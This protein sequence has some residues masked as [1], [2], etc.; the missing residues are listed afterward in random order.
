MNLQLLSISSSERRDVKKF[1]KKLLAFALLVFVLDKGLAYWA[2][3]AVLHDTRA[4]GTLSLLY[5]GEVNTQIVFF[6]SSKTHVNI[7][8]EAVE[9]QT[10]MSAYNLALGNSSIEM[11]EFLFEE[12]LIQNE[13]P[14][15]VFL[16]ADYIHLE[17]GSLHFRSELL[18]PFSNVSA[19]TSKRLNPTAADRLA[20][21]FFRCKNFSS[22]G[23]IG[24]L[25]RS[26]INYARALIMGN[27]ITGNTLHDRTPQSGA[28]A[29]YQDNH[30]WR[31]AHGS[32]LVAPLEAEMTRD[33]LWRD[34]MGEEITIAAQRREVY[35]RIAARTKAEGIRLVL[36]EPPLFSRLNE[37]LADEVEQFF[38][39]LAAHNEHVHYWSFRENPNLITDAALWN[40]G[41]HMNWNGA[42]ILSQK[43]A[44]K[45]KTLQ[46]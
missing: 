45:L 37:H 25:G 12:L 11:S 23:G 41:V 28:A 1:F 5:R 2:T 19:H 20:F 8:A 30:Q 4:F 14:D 46:E 13:K 24:T 16:E 22:G 43:I 27:K 6:G 38:M 7:D 26:M 9:Q 17:E 32:H 10:G 36:I 18:A 21:W 3:Q 35:L 33:R 29:G 34:N 44:E 42:A 39:Q 40:D 15:I 31:Y